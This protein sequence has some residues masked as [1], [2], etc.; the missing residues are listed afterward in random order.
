MLRE[1]KFQLKHFGKLSLAEQ[2]LLTA[3]DRQW[4]IQRLNKLNDDL[5]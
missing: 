3:E 2:Q 5:R 1:Q 4:W